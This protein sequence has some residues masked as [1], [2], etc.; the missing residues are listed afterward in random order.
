MKIED[1]LQNI[2]NSCSRIAYLCANH[3]LNKKFL[4]E[5]E[6]DESILCDFL[7]NFDNYDKLLNDY[8][9][10]IYNRF[11][12]SKD[13]VFK[14]ICLF[15]NEDF[16]NKYLFEYRL[17]RVLNQDPFKYL[18]MDDQDMQSEAINRVYD[19]IEIIEN[20]NYYKNNKDKAIKDI[21]KL[22]KSL[23]TVKMAAGIR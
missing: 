18:N 11:E 2:Q 3:M 19:K 5:N 13:E 21:E 15:L 12:S 17:T 20:S 22:K 7:I 16:D 1:L 4:I 6:I 14:E 9:N 23:E 10:I 8:A